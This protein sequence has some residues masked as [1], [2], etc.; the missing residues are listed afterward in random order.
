MILNPCPVL[1]A[2]NVSPGALTYYKDRE[3][4]VARR[5]R[6]NLEFVFANS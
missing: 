1:Y 5:S 4:E 6:D 3:V 2:C